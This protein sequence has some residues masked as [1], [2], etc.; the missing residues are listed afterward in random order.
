MLTTQQL[1]L[2][3]KLADSEEGEIVCEGNVCFIDLDAQ[4]DKRDVYALLRVTAISDATDEGGLLE[5]YRLNSTGR[6]ILFNPE[7]EHQITQA[8]QQGGLSA[9]TIENHTVKPI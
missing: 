1:D 2:L 3:K 8:L 6:A 9:F 5:R 7:I 4:V